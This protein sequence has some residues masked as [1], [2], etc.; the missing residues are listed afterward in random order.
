MEKCL[1]PRWRYECDNVGRGLSWNKWIKVYQLR[2][3][4]LNVYEI[5]LKSV[6]MMES[7]QEDGSLENV[8]IENL[9]VEEEEKEVMIREDR[10]ETE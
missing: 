8:K 2:G 4:I 3:K 7:E 10:G 6:N 5:P 1:T 9:V